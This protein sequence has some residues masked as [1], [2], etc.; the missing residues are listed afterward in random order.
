V[1]VAL[2]ERALGGATLCLLRVLPLLESRGWRFSFWVPGRGAAEQ[3]LRRRGHEVETA[4]RLMRF[5][6]RGLRESPGAL[7][8]LASTPR[9]LR[10]W[11]AWLAEQEAEL[12]HAN[13]V[14]SLPE[15]CARPRGGPPVVLQV[16]EVLGSGVEGFAAALLARRVDTVVCVSEAAA[17]PFRARGIEPEIVYP[18][19]PDAPSAPR[20]D[21]RTRL[22]VGMLGTV[23][24]H[25]GSDLF[26]A[27]ARR[28]RGTGI[29]FRIA[30]GPIAGPERAWAE[31]LLAS[32]A[33][34]GVVHRAWVDPYEELSD[35]DVLLSPSR[36]EAFGLTVLEA[37]A[38]GV[39]V[40]ASRVGGIPEQLDE[41][42]GILVEPEDVDG[43]VD[44]VRRLAADQPLRASL[45]EAG[46]RRHERRFTLERQAEQLDAA[47]RS[48]LAAAEG[49]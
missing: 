30:G 20:R 27:V 12:I 7:R 36:T 37:M 6:L 32:A 4:E 43:L 48:S 18:A 15:A 8:R 17:R 9:Y 42:A 26:V 39:P 19:V 2:H 22:V 49:A 35:W 24:R 45:G 33:A 21:G 46:R 14:L 44:A 40:V 5:S 38:M 34:D 25:K 28:L 10:A 29:E 41:D 23:S 3:E 31:G 1:A 47:Y 11:R 13:S 16:H